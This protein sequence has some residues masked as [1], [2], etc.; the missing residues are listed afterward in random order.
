MQETD[1]P[2]TG[3]IQIAV[4][5]EEDLE[6]GLMF[7][8]PGW[9]ETLRIMIDGEEVSG[10]E[11]NGYLLVRKIWPAS[12]SGV[13]LEMKMKVEYVRAGINDE[14]RVAVKYGP[15]VLAIDSRYGTPIRNTRIRMQD[16]P[17]LEPAGLDDQQGIPQVM[18]RVPGMIDGKEGKITLVD[19]ASAGSLAP[20]VDEFRLWLPVYGE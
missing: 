2:A 7:R 6:F 18:F 15:L 14:P 13:E 11:L 12:G 17:V 5:P 20:G 10:E 19:Y 3:S 1:Y 9:C 4:Q 16:S 8:K